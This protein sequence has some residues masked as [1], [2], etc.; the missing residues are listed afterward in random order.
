MEWCVSIERAMDDE[1][2][3]LLVHEAFDEAKITKVFLCSL[4]QNSGV[5]FENNNKYFS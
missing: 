5:D 2:M 4:K 3:W 1:S